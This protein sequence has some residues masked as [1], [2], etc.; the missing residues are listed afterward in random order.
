MKFIVRCSFYGIKRL[1]IIVSLARV[2]REGKKT[3]E[4]TFMV[5]KHVQLFALASC[6]HCGFTGFREEIYVP[7]TPNCK[8]LLIFHLRKIIDFDDQRQIDYFK[9]QVFIFLKM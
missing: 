2:F 5:N 7:Q 9:L 3:Y 6:M 1:L 8:R 4:T